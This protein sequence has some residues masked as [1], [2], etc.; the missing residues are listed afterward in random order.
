VW[1]AGFSNWLSGYERLLYSF[2]KWKQRSHICWPLLV[3]SSTPSSTYGGSGHFAYTSV[4]SGGLN[5][6][7]YCSSASVTDATGEHIYLKIHIWT[8]VYDF[9][10][11]SDE[12]RANLALQF[13]TVG[14]TVANSG[15]LGTNDRNGS[16]LDM[17]WGERPKINAHITACLE[18]SVFDLLKSI[19]KKSAKFHGPSTSTQCVLRKEHHCNYWAKFVNEL[20]DHSQDVAT[21]VMCT[22]TA[23]LPTLG[24]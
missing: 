23:Y 3:S 12:V 15:K 9:R 24:V 1:V 14:L 22:I 18:Q 4:E 20:D 16:L 11:V 17:K 8:K 7:S 19:K 5:A 13:N 21:A 2:N 10:S 6:F